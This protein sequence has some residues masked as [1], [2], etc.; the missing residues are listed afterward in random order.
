MRAVT[1]VLLIDHEDSFTFNL[2]QALAA[3]GADVE[4]V[5]D[6]RLAADAPLPE[7]ILLGPGPGGPERRTRTLALLDRVDAAASGSAPR[8]LGVCLGLQLVVHHRR[9][10]VARA[11]RPMHGF[12]EAMEHDGRGVFRGLASPVTMARYHSLVATEPLPPDLEVSARSAG[13]EIMGLRSVTRPIECVQFHP[14]SILSSDGQALLSNFV[15]PR[16]PMAPSG[17]VHSGHGP[18][19]G[20]RGSGSDSF[21]NSR[22]SPL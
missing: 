6:D 20:R 2:V 7:A 5:R 18:V 11:L 12:A 3:L 21:G 17:S 8:V 4:V 22:T 13:G 15:S 14:E 10:R 9:G 1:R 16:D 19:E